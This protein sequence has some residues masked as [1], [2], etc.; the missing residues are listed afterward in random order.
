MASSVTK[1]SLNSRDKPDL[2]PLVGESPEFR[3]FF[4]AA[5]LNS[6][7]IL[8]GM[9]TTLTAD[10][11]TPLLRLSPSL[12][13]GGGIGKL[14]ANWIIDGKSEFDVTGINVDRMHH[15]QANPEYR[16]SR[17]VESLGMV[18]SHLSSSSITSAA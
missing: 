12:T 16:S 8:T 7:G 5:G 1:R 4:V 18:L 3:N 17:V 6:I 15:Y 13:P 11:Y 14:V 9:E 10:K 2:S